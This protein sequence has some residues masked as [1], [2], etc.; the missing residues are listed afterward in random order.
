MSDFT[1]LTPDTVL[2]VAEE[3]LGQR[4]SGYYS[5]LNSYI[6]RVYEIETDNNE[7]FILK[8]YRPDRWSI[9]MILEEHQFVQEL[10]DHDLPVV[11][12]LPLHSSETTLGDCKGIPFAIYHK[13]S[14][15]YLDEYNLDQWYALG[16]LIGR[17]HLVSAGKPT[18]SRNI[19]LPHKITTDQVQFLV[20]GDFIPREL[21]SQFA[22]T[23]QQLIELI[24]LRFTDLPLIRLHG[25]C[26]WANILNRGNESFLLFDFDDMVMGPAVQDL[27]MLLP[28]YR[29]DSLPEIASFL[30][31]YE[32]FRPF[33]RRELT[34]IE[35]LRGMRFIHYIAWCAH[36]QNDNHTPPNTENWGDFSYWQ[37]EMHDLEQQI[38][39]IEMEKPFENSGLQYI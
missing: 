30:E 35:P 3:A 11:I 16:H 2:D 33:N 20:Q 27:W 12:P 7:R 8:F 34:L 1:I 18:A 9:P 5:Q 38:R 21:C 25:D 17:M 26:H 31:G 36:Q 14:G 23:C 32:E 15:R 13:R 37:Q 19:L 10:Y 6:N 39:R 24:T 22:D 4:C 28:G 29:E